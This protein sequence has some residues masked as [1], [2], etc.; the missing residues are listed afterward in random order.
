ML[1]IRPRRRA[2]VVGH[3]EWVRQAVLKENVSGLND[4]LFFRV[5]DPIAASVIL[6]TRKETHRRSVVK[7][8]QSFFRLD[9]G[10]VLRMCANAKYPG[11]PIEQ[12]VRGS[13]T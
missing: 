3:R 2:G 5:L 1:L 8:H 9:N 6:V 4:N 7:L 11:S 12:L 13:T 10:A